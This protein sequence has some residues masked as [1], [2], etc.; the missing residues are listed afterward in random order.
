MIARVHR[1]GPPLGGFV[2]CLW[3]Y[4]GYSAG[5]KR[6]RALPTGTV[7]LVVNLREDRIHVFRDESDLS[8]FH[9][10]GSILCGPHSGYFVLD[11]T[12]QKSVVGVHFKPG[13]AAPFLGAPADEF[14]DRHIGLEDVWGVQARQQRDRLME[15]RAPEAMFTVLESALLARLVRQLAPGPAVAAAL[16]QLTR[17]PEVTRIGAVCGESGYGAKRFIELFRAAV[18][19]TPKVYCRIQRFQGVVRRLANGRSVD[20][21]GVAVGS[22]YCDQSHLNREF[23]AF[24]GVTPGQYK[25]VD[26]DRPNHVAVP[27]PLR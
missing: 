14:T 18:G 13:G 19:L 25:P 4:N 27:E 21:A 26:W 3:Y 17:A 9:C 6:E 8:G 16:V 11:T 7:E 1:P 5:H 12:Q 23:R 24:S 15:A 20:W 2:D 22:G 10:R